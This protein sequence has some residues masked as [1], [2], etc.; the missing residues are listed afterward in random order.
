MQTIVTQVIESPIGPLHLGATDT[1][2]CLLEFA[3]RSALPTEIRQ[4]DKFIGLLS[5]GSNSHLERMADQ[6]A[7]Y[8]AG[9]LTKFSVP[10]DLV[11]GTPFQREVWDHL[12]Q[13]PYGETMSYGEV[14]EALGRP[15][16]QR[17]VGSANRANYIAIVIPCHRVVQ[18]S[19]KL[20]GYGGGLERKRF[21]LDHEAAVC[22]TSLLPGAGS[23]GDGVSAPH[24][25]CR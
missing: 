22:G 20:G 18:G 13:I 23:S 8:F 12:L 21:L 24:G 9:T 25:L 11:R 15:D 14:A 2:V 1:G 4:L 5:P 19:G 7:R 17:A 3:D 10:L 16:A 6:L